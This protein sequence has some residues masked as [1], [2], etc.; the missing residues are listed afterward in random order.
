MLYAILK[1][2]ANVAIR[3]FFRQI[4]VVNADRVPDSAPV[5]IAANHPSTFMDA[6]VIGAYIRQPLYFLAKGSLFGSRFLQFVF[7]SL[8]MIPIHRRQDDPTRMNEND[9]AFQQCYDYLSQG[10]ALLIF[11]EGVSR[12]ERRLHKM[13]TGTARIALGAEE[14][15]GYRLGLR[16]IPVGLNYSEVGIFR[17]EVY[18]SFA[19][20]VDVSPYFATYRKDS[21]GAVRSL[22]D[23]IGEC[24]DDH[25][26]NIENDRLAEFIGNIETI[27]KGL[28]TDETGNTPDEEITDHQ[29]SKGIVDAVKYYNQE[30]PQ[31]LENLHH[32]VRAYMDHLQRLHLR[33]DVLQDG[34]RHHSLLTTSIKT[35]TYLLLGLPIYLYGVVNNYPAYKLIDW[36]THKTADAIEYQ[37][38]TKLVLGIAVFPLF[39]ALQCWGVYAYCGTWW[40]ML[41]YLITLPI[42]GFF[43]LHYWSR[44]VSTR[45]LLSFFSIFYQRTH[46]VANLVQQRQDIVSSLEEARSDYQQRTEGERRV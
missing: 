12:A 31:R 2:T 17:S 20:P 19:D 8:H 37:G 23:H 43:A 34:S 4:R 28:L 10:K 15:N 13:K 39:Y 7:R 6:M 40:L 5:I 3:V 9:R 14:S 35:T 24:L 46:H 25:T 26:I 38:P 1:S 45:E 29:M 44:L 33:D 32:K 22:T 42:G 11:P 27:Y 30:D 21:S 18:I 36:L 16:I 41:L